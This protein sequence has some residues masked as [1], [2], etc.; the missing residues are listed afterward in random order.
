MSLTATKHGPEQ[1]P[2][3]C[4]VCGGRIHFNQEAR[5]DEEATLHK[6]GRDCL[7]HLRRSM[8]RQGVL[9]RKM[10]RALLKGGA[11]V[12]RIATAKATEETW[13]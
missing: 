8:E 7:R 2:Q 1:E 4:H 12:E 11:L 13:D 9:I 5:T 3:D 10:E 6:D